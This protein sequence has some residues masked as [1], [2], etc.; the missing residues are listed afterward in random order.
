[1]VNINDIP[2]WLADAEAAELRKLATNANV[3]EI[4]SYKGRSTIAMA[5]VANFVVAVDHHRGDSGCI[6]GTLNAF[7]MNLEKYHV[8]EKVV[9]MIA[10]SVMSCSLLM[11][12]LFDL[13]FIDGDH[14]VESVRRD[15]RA[16]RRLVRKGGVMAFHDADYESVGEAMRVCGL[17]GGY[18]VQRTQFITV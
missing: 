17:E 15:V 18:R 14:A 3:L 10:D 12:G 7:L 4:G 8:R 5:E 1:M 16:V 9:L 6:G 11:N 2:G 13:V